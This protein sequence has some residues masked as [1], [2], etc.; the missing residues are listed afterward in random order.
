MSVRRVL[1]TGGA[2]FVGYHLARK[3]NSEPESHVFLLDN[4]E[5]GKRDR[6]LEE[7]LAHDR[8]DLVSGDL[9]DQKILDGLGDGFDEVYH[10]AA[11]IGVPNV[12]QRPHEVVRINALTTLNLLR[13]FVEGGAKKILF[14]ST[15]EAYAWTQKF[16]SLPIP[17]PEDIPLSLT[18]LKNP[19]SSY[20]GSKIFGELAVHQYGSLYDKPYTIVRFHNVYGPRMG[21]EHVMPQLCHRAWAG[22]HPL[23]VYSAGYQR[24][25]CYVADAVRAVIACMRNDSANGQTI[26]I[27][28]DLEEIAMGDLAKMIL[29]WLGKSEEIVPKQAENDPITRRCPDI[30]RARSLLGYEPEVG[31]EEGLDATLSWYV[32]QFEEAEETKTAR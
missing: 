1:I 9:T 4:F 25:F 6:D 32:R 22:Q 5:R 14:S 11:I 30:T 29:R 21:N 27:G 31:L 7:L 13:W 23:V 10:L 17:T 26:N 8:I 15:S 24:A 3:L 12:L 16:H 2:G 28:N 18:D 19:R 20:A